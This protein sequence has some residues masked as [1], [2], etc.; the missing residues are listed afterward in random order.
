MKRGRA[1][2][3]FGL[4]IEATVC[5]DLGGKPMPGSGA[6]AGAKGDFVI[7]PDFL[8]E[9]KGTKQ[10]SYAIKYATLQ[11]IVAEAYGA[12]REPLFAFTFC[13]P[14]GG[15]K[16]TGSW[17]AMPK[18]VFKSLLDKAGGKVYD[19]EYYET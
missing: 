19:D 17:V 10:L 13:K 12:N 7:E 11:K 15:I 1:K 8:V 5:N 9:H 3:N 14:D 16:P 2:G 18:D 6:L 4:T